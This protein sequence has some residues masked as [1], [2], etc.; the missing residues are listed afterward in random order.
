MF[1]TIPGPEGT[2]LFFVKSEIEDEV[3]K[4]QSHIVAYMKMN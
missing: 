3:T 1:N 2:N 4:Q